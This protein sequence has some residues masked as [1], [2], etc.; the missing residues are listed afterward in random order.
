[1]RT[2]II[3]LS[4][5]LLACGEQSKQNTDD[6]PVHVEDTDTNDEAKDFDGDGFGEDVDCDDENPDVH[7][8]ALEICDGIDNDCDAKIDDE[9]DSTAA[10]RCSSMF[11]M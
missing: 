6:S 4:I 7:P 11:W 2:K 5:F 10:A 9:D 1:M 8:D 3:P